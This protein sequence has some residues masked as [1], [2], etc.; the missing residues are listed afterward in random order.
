MNGLTSLHDMRGVQSPRCQTQY[1]LFHCFGIA[2]YYE[3]FI[4]E[5][6]CK[7]LNKD[8]RLNNQRLLAVSTIVSEDQLIENQI[9]ICFQ[10]D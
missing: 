1:Y 10:H 4:V 3:I 8:L 7:N 2:N 6:I 9:T 5:N